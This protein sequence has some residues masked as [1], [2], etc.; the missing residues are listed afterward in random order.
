MKPR[1]EFFQKSM[2]ARI[3]IALLIGAAL[4]SACNLLETGEEKAPQKVFVLVEDSGNER[5]TAFRLGLEQ[6]AGEYGGDVTFITSSAFHNAEEEKSL[7]SQEAAAGT[8]ALILS[9]YDSEET[10]RLPGTM[11][12]VFVESDGIRDSGA[13]TCAVVPSGYKMGKALG[14]M[15]VSDWGQEKDLSAAVLVGNLRRYS[16]KEMLRGVTECIEEAGG[17]VLTL[18]TEGEDLSAVMKEAGK[19]AM[20]AVLEDSLLVQA[21]AMAASDDPGGGRLYGAGCSPSN[22]SWLDRG[23]IRGMVVPDEFAMGY[24]S[25]SQLSGFLSNDI[26]AMKDIEIGF[27]CVRAQEVHSPDNEKLLFLP[28]Q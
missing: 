9:P 10:A 20:T 3:V 26:P 1:N 5:W 7:I 25:L 21:A 24:Q 19:C 18:E 23:V 2:N 28:I 11:K 6:A 13:G 4:W 22:I 12:L 8:N 15:M 14:E 16:E 27:I 17:R